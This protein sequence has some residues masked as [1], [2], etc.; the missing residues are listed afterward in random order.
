ME[1]IA[2][3]DFRLENHLFFWLTLVLES[4]NR[5]LS[6]ELRALYLR[7]PGWRVLASLFARQRLSMGEPADLS[8]VD[9]TT[10]SRTVGRMV[11]AG[12]ISRISGVAHMCVTRLR[13]TDAGRELFHR[14]WPFI[15]R[16]NA[17]ATRSLPDA[18]VGM[19]LWVLSEMKRNLDQFPVSDEKPPG[20]AQT[21]RDSRTPGR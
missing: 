19:A 7:V 8:T 9:R 12:W 5:R 20:K 4:R 11:N 2:A 21:A 14:A 10:L 15:E 1:H 16:A 3:E 6:Q 17:T 18:A 13:L